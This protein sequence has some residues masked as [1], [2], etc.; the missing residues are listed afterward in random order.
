[1]AKLTGIFHMNETKDILNCFQKMTYVTSTS[2]T[3]TFCREATSPRCIVI[4]F[5]IIKYMK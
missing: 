1:M 2:D 3:G 5:V 4:W